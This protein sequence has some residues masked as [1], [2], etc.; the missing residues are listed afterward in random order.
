[1]PSRLAIAQR[2]VNGSL[3]RSLSHVWISDELLHESFNR[4]TTTTTTFTCNSK[5]HGSNVP[6]PLEARKRLSGRRLNNSASKRNTAPASAPFEISSL[7]SEWG[8]FEGFGKWR[9][10]AREVWKWQPPSQSVTPYGGD[11]AGESLLG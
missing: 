6:G 10:R 5:R 3:D 9:K 11:D 4:F 7:W 2:A 1:M 8:E